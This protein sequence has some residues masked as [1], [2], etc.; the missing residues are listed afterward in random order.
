MECVLYG[1]GKPMV[2]LIT[3]SEVTPLTSSLARRLWHRILRPNVRL[4]I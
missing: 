2:R 3:I 1:H 4:P